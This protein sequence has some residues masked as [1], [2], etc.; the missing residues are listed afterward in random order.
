MTVAEPVTLI[1][2]YLLA[3][4]YGTLAAKLKRRGA[5]TSTRLAAAALLVT[6]TAAALGGTYHGWPSVPLWKLTVYSLGLAD[7]LT[8]AA[9]V[10][11]AFRGP[12]R[13]WVLRLAAGK[14][15]VY[16]AWITFHD[17]FRYVIYDYLPALAAVVVFAFL[18]DRRG[19]SRSARWI[20]AAAL[21]TLAGSAVQQS[22]FALHRHFNHNDLYHV[23][24]MGAAWLFYRGFGEFRD[25]P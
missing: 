3:A 11:A 4:V 10:F 20:A 17:E 5:A 14:L 8:V 9:A 18:A 19:Q 2:D 15:A 22:G 24:Q 21:V 6:G 12:S 13:R 7:F 1:T 25:Y 23:I 16:L